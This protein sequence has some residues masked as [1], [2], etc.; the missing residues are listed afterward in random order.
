MVRDGLIPLSSVCR[1]CHPRFMPIKALTRVE[2][3]RLHPRAQWHL[4]DWR[5]SF[6]ARTRCGRAWG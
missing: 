5:K 4:I 3:V 1:R 2:L 6:G